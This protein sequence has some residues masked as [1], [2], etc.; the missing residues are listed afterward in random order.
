MIDVAA[1]ET[2][3]GEAAAAA[4]PMVFWTRELG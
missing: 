1:I 3:A 4:K 2:L